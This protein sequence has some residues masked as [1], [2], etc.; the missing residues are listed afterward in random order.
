MKIFLSVLAL[1]GIIFPTTSYVFWF[2][3]ICGYYPHSYSDTFKGWIKKFGVG[4]RFQ[5]WI[6]FANLFMAFG[7]YEYSVKWYE[8]LLSFGAMFYLGLVALYPSGINKEITKYHCIFAKLCATSAV[9][10]L[11]CKE[12]YILTGS[13]ILIGLTWSHFKKEYETL[14]MEAMAFL[15]VYIGII[16][17]NIG[18]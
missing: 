12:L 3:N 14:I 17:L 11:L 10:W 5:C 2:K 1:L 6:V 15:G 4:F 8:Y 18:V 9:I 7:L 16:L 13:L